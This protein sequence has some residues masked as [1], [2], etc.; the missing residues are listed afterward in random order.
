[1]VN[2]RRLLVNNVGD[3]EWFVKNA[4]SPAFGRLHWGRLPLKLAPLLGGWHDMLMRVSTNVYCI[5]LLFLERN[6]VCE[7]SKHLHIYIY[8]IIV[9]KSLIISKYIYVIWMYDIL[10]DDSSMHNGCIRDRI[11]VGS[12]WI[13]LRIGAS[14]VPS[15]S[16]KCTNPQL[17]WMFCVRF[18]TRAS[19]WKHTK[20]IDSHRGCLLRSQQKM[21]KTR[22]NQW[23][24]TCL[25]WFQLITTQLLANPWGDMSHTLLD[26]L[27]APNLQSS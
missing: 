11:I 17:S 16:L 25:A 23:D 18:T 4:Y 22:R 15:A 10:F 7:S 26:M 2:I 8:I 21:Q 24:V 20:A 6:C 19:A 3:S 27:K 12:Q 5:K 13:V 9:Y 1:M 14:T